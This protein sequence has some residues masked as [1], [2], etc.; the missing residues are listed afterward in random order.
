MWHQQKYSKIHILK[1]F[2]IYTIFMYT[3]RYQIDR[4]MKNADMKNIKNWII[5]YST[6]E[7][8]E[9]MLILVAMPEKKLTGCEVII[10]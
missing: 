4:Q 5:E 8:A 10:M 7:M 1:Q 9:I 3:Y 6:L 2:H